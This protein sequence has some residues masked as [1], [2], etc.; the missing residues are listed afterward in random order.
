M[1]ADRCFQVA[2]DIHEEGLENLKRA[3]DSHV[4]LHDAFER[5]GA[6]HAAA[7]TTERAATQSVKIGNIESALLT[8]RKVGRYHSKEMKNYTE[9]NKLWR[10][11][12]A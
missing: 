9:A 1:K 2:R 3:A 12:T 8:M 4:H 11:V 7:Q 5:C 10:R 6:H